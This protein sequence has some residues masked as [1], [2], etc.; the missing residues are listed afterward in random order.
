MSYKEL[1]INTKCRQGA[2]P[3]GDGR[4]SVSFTSSNSRKSKSPDS[5]LLHEP[6][7]EAEAGDEDEL[8]VTGTQLGLLAVEGGVAQGFTRE[9]ES[10][11][12]RQVKASVRKSSGYVSRV[13]EG[14]PAVR[15]SST[16]YLQRANGDDAKWR[17]ESLLVGFCP[18]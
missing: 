10:R 6:T 8:T 14:A 13:R 15:L 5:S 18:F 17:C 11:R 9:E 2:N 12:V 4:T 1:P 7:E 16:M 3:W